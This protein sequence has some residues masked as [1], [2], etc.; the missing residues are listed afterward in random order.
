MIHIQETVGSIPSP[1]TSFDA[2]S[3]KGLREGPPGLGRPILISEALMRHL[4]VLRQEA[5]ADPVGHVL[6]RGGKAVGISLQHE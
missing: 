4:W 5:L 2:Y 3:S 1:P 6:L